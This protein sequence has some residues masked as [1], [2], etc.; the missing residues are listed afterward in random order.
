MTLLEIY[1]RGAESKVLLLSIAFTYNLKSKFIESSWRPL[2]NDRNCELT[3]FG[4]NLHLLN[5]ETQTWRD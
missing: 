4:L 3:D 1:F 2:N 5:E